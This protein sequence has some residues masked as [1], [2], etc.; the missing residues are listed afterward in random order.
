MFGRLRYPPYF[1]VMPGTP[2]LLGVAAI[3]GPVPRTLREWA[4]AE[5]AFEIS[6]AIIPRLARG[7][8]IPQVGIP[9]AALILVLA[10]YRT[11]RRRWAP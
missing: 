8:P 9:T 1:A 2:Q 11:W 3:L 5:L 4:Y 10:R 7:T 6:A